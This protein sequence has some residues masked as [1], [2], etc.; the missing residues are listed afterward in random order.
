VEAVALLLVE[1]DPRLPALEPGGVAADL[2]PE[3]GEL[4]ALVVAEHVARLAA[5][6][7]DLLDLTHA[8][9]GIHGGGIPAA[10]S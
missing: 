8:D 3:G 5:A 2:G 1:L 9:H 7:L 4:A 10:R 6:G